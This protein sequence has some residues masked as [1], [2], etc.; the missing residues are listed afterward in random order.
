[1]QIMT[2][3]AF[4]GQRRQAFEVYERVLGR[5]ITLMNTFGDSAAKLPP[6]NRPASRSANWPL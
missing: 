3:L 2:Q 6:T 5:R 1:M 4:G